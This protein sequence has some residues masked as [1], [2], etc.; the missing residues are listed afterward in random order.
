M[1]LSTFDFPFDPTLIASRPIEPRDQ[2]RLLVV[3]RRTGS[4]RH[5]RVADLAALLH[6]GD[7]VVANDTKVLPARVVGRKLD[8]GRAVEVL[9]VRP[10]DPVTWV[11][12]MKGRWRVGQRIGL[13]SDVSATI[14]RRDEGET[15]VRIDGTRPLR[16]LLEESGGMPLPP[17]I[18]RSPEAA[19][20]IWYQTIFA[21]EE[22]AIAAPTAGL[23][24][25]DRLLRAL[26]EEGVEWA[27]VTLHV[28][29]GTFKPVAAACIEAHR[30]EPE[31]FVVTEAASEA[32]R[33]ARRRQGRVV[34]VGT[35]VVRT[36]ESSVDEAG[37]IRA[38]SGETALYVTPGYQFRV[39]DALLTNF[40]L[41]KTTL[42]MLV[43]AFAGLDLIREAYRVAVEERYRFYSY[44]DAMLLL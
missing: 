18:K 17:Y 35:T 27:T 23:H 9:F 29:P 20:R 40:H 12:M 6:K 3:D 32:V 43:S 38:G 41:P 2:A 1:D 42:L 34:A 37:E 22:G 24:L 10:V 14:L 4:I 5:G 26:A 28:G 33:R 16:V 8:T 44:G 11:V 13:A 39:V 30:M 15:T 19:D 21:R 36:L 31:R 7:L 25:T